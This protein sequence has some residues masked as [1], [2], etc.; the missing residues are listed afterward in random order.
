[1][2]A[3]TVN[4]AK[5]VFVVS[6]VLVASVVVPAVH[7]QEAKGAQEAKD[8]QEAKQ[9]PDI[10]MLLTQPQNRV[11]ADAA[12]VPDL[13]D[14]P[15]PKMDKPPVQPPITIMLGD[16][17]CYPGED[18]LGDFAQFNRRSRRTH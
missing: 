11:S 8:T 5:I 13:R 3:G 1:V 14:V 4:T 18:G 6:V 16:P 12:A 17:R 9:P 2:E 15:M 10:R 7:A